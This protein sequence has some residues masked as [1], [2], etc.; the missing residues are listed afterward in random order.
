VGR[1]TVLGIAT[2]STSISS[3]GQ[4]AKIKSKIETAIT[5][6][7]ISKFPRLLVHEKV[8]SLQYT[9]T[10]KPRLVALVFRIDKC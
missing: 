10:W 5:L 4:V 2:N 7:F 1:L 9:K 3:S 6:Y 8:L